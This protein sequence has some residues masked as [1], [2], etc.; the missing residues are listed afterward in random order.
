MPLQVTRHAP[1]KH[2][3]PYIL[4]LKLREQNARL[5]HHPKRL[6]RSWDNNFSFQTP[7]GHPWR[8][9]RC[10]TDGGNHKLA[11]SS[12]PWTLL[13]SPPFHWTGVLKGSLAQIEGTS[14]TIVRISQSRLRH[15]IVFRTKGMGTFDVPTSSYLFEIIDRRINNLVNHSHLL[16]STIGLNSETQTKNFR[17]VK[18]IYK[19]LVYHKQG[20]GPRSYSWRPQK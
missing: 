8:L 7:N 9:E 14:P 15:H 17:S 16:Q 18:Y 11:P 20:T 19:I 12:W 6:F 2:I 10:R 4:W 1:R 5:L 13:R 3:P